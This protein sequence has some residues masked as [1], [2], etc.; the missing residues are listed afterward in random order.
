MGVLVLGVS[1]VN[2]GGFYFGFWFLLISCVLMFLIRL[3][4]LFMNYSIC[5]YLFLSVVW[6]LGRV[7]VLWMVLSV[8]VSLVGVSFFRSLVVV[9]D[10]V[11]LCVCR[12]LMILF[13]VFV[14]KVLLIYFWDV[15]SLV[16][17]GVLLNSSMILLGLVGLVWKVSV[18]CSV[19]RCLDGMKWFVNLRYMV[20]VLFIV[21]FV[22]LKYLLKCLGVW[23]SS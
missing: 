13:I 4:C 20:L 14:E 8:I 6:S 10:L 2:V 22:R 1:L 23:L 9:V 11:V 21:D 12:C 17:F 5:W 19:L 18:L 7:F 3:G 16:G 15:G